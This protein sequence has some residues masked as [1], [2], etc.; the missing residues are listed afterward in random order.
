MWILAPPPPPKK[1]PNTQDTAH[2]TQKVNKLNGPSEDASVPLGEGG[3]KKA[4]SNG[5]GG[6]WEGKGMGKWR[7]E[8]DQALGG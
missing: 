2:R 1:V 7:G 8:D 4:T 5:E 6:T 3:E